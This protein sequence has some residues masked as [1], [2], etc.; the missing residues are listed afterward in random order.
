MNIQLKYLKNVL[1][2]SGIILKRSDTLEEWQAK[3]SDIDDYGCMQ[4]VRVYG[5]NDNVVV[6]L[7]KEMR[8]T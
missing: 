1:I 8:E 6:E 4:V 2:C 3:V 5:S 7:Q